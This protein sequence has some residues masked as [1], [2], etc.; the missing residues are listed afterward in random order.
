MEYLIFAGPYRCCCCK[1]FS[2][3][4]ILFYFGDNC[5]YL[6]SSLEIATH[7]IIINIFV[8]VTFSFS[9]VLWRQI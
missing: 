3:D 8:F 6:N 9:P 5:Y 1:L 7:S 4:F 2:I